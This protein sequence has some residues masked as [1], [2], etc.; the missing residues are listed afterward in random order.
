MKKIKLILVSLFA[1]AMT[2][3]CDDDGGDSKINVQE[4]AIPNIQKVE[5]SESFINLSELQAGNDIS[6]SVDLSIARGL[7]H[8][9]SVNV[10]GFYIK[11]DGTIEKGILASNLTTFPAVVLIKKE[12]LLNTFTNLDTA[13]DFAIGDELKISTDITLKDGTVLKLLK[14]DS[15]QN[16]GA[17]IANSTQITPPINVT[18]SYFVSCPSDLGGTYSVVTSGASTDSGPTPDENPIS[19]YMTTVTITDNGGGNYTMSDAYGGLYLLWY[20]M[21]GITAND[22]KGTFT[23]VCGVISSTFDPGNFEGETVTLTGTVNDDGTLTIHWENT[24]GDFGD[25]VYTKN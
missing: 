5:G 10:V 7:K 24:F 9:A 17:D 8:V 1:V 16:Y 4:G 22:T 13:D 6:I 23:D 20:D 18:Q 12:T 21:Y 14:D 2:L 15:T 25:S 11:A 19:D 3:S